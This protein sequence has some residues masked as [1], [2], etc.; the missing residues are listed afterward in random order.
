LDNQDTGHW[1]LDAGKKVAR[2]AQALA[3]RVARLLFINRQNTSLI[4]YQASSIQNLG[5]LLVQCFC[6]KN[7]TQLSTK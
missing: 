4:Q 2:S 7:M 5:Q 1:M 6:P 3:P